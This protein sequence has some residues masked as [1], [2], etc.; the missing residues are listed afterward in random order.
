MGFVFVFVVRRAVG[1]VGVLTKTG[2]DPEEAAPVR[3]GLSAAC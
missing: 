1:L 3:S 2:A